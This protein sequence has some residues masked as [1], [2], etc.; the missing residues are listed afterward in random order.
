[1]GA[2]RLVGS[3]PPHRRDWRLTEHL[4]A[5]LDYLHI[6][7]RSIHTRAAY[8]GDIRELIAFLAR[9]HDTPRQSTIDAHDLE[10][11]KHLSSRQAAVVLRVSH[12]AVN[13][14]RHPPPN[15]AILRL[16][17]VDLTFD[18][19]RRFLAELHRKIVKG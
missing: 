10:R 9:S 8:D 3:L 14:A 2:C 11:T 1:M 13:L 15:P 6:Q 17:A 18:A 16:R 12:T 7:N 5:F 19:V 4:R